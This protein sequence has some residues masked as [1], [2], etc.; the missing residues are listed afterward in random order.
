M[1]Q[2]EI[3]SG[4]QSDWA[5]LKKLGE[6]DAGE[7][8]LVRSQSQT[9]G[10]DPAQGSIAILK[11]PRKSP[12]SSDV[13]RQ[14]AQ[15]ETEGRILKAIHA[16]PDANG[17]QP[18]A[19]LE[20]GE[21][22]AASGSPANETATSTEAHP[23]AKTYC[24]PALLDTAPLS[25][26]ASDRYFI[27]IEKAPGFDLA[28]LARVAM[29]GRVAAAGTTLTPEE[30]LYLHTISQSRKVP[31][32]VVLGALVGLLDLF[33]KIHSLPI[34]GERDEP[35]AAGVIWNDVKPEHL[36]WDPTRVEGDLPAL[37]VIDWG[38]GR[39]LGSDGA[40]VDRRSSRL[41]D[42][43]Q[44]V[45]EMGRFLTLT[46]PDLKA[47]LGWPEQVT[48]ETASPAGFQVLKKKL[49]QALAECR[50]GLKAARKHEAAFFKLDPQTGDPFSLL[51]EV[52]RQ[53]VAYGA[54]PDYAAALLFSQSYAAVFVQEDR[55]DTLRA[56]A[57]WAALLPQAQPESWATIARIAGLAAA[58][59]GER[60][61]RFLDAVQ[62]VVVQDWEAVLWH[63]VEAI[64]DQPEPDWW[65]DLSAVVRRQSLQRLQGQAG[66]PA[67]AGGASSLLTP[68]APA[69]DVVPLVSVKRIL[70]ALQA[71]IRQIEDRAAAGKAPLPGANGHPAP[72]AEHLRALVRRLREEI[73]PNWLRVDP[74]PPFSNLLYTDIDALLEELAGEMPDLGDA[75]LQALQRPRQAAGAVLD[76]W[77]RQEFVRAG[78]LL[79]AVLLVDPDRRRVLRADR[80]ILNTP[81]WLK[82]VQLGPRRSENLRDFATR[83]EFEGRELR[84][85]VGPAD[86][87]DRILEACK[88]LRRSAWPADLLAADPDLIREMPWLNVFERGDGG[89][90]AESREQR[91]EN[92]QRVD[93][94]IRNRSISNWSIGDS[95]VSSQ[96]LIP[97]PESPISD[98]QSPIT[99]PQSLFTGS[100]GP[101]ADMELSAA[102]DA[103]LPEAR[104]SSARVYSGRLLQPDGQYLPAA[105][106][107][108][109]VDK[110]D[111]ALPLFHEEAQI[112]NL[113]NGV[114][115]VTPMLECGFIH[116]EKDQ[117]L[118]DETAA[119]SPTGE[120]LR[121]GADSPAAFQAEL[122]ARVQAGWVPY[123]AIEPQ[124]KK[125]CLL[126]FCDA[127]YTRGRFL[128][129]PE[130]VRMSI[131]ICDLLQIAHDRSIVYRDHKILHYYW[132]REQN[133]VWM[134][135]WNVARYHPEG[136][137][138]VEK[139]MDLVQFGARAL[140]HILTGRT[141]P[142]A[143]PMGPTRPEEIENAASTYE[144]QWTYD[145]QR[146]TEELKGIL[147]TVLLGGYTRPDLLAVDLKQA[148]FHLS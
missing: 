25:A 95:D 38:N 51:T 40:T 74:A 143:L 83:V 108:M 35:G 2:P 102:L 50:K 85:Q 104:G 115:G 69:A 119:T 14:A 16:S 121:I 107:L 122:A 124:A 142:G 73:I 39:M 111:Y 29:M 93:P 92:G 62:S 19:E 8:Y 70:L 34:S 94:V 71:V 45:E 49:R 110:T 64:Y 145:D 133:S 132:I 1:L 99:N 78:Q 125:D 101:N 6:G 10:Q 59:E 112:L 81:G 47:R 21:A 23:Q 141:A 48:F 53:I 68:A 144:V 140:H 77:K 131:Q 72:D 27:V 118:P 13:L 7:V 36:F 52:H 17:S 97:D 120:L 88:Q 127:G 135:D 12:F 80:A 9:P 54:M 44:L 18:D 11:R 105:V 96:S 137:T 103:W 60:R 109:R 5:L 138:E 128:P 130:L 67:P 61:R 87:L 79:R 90:R 116:F 42:Y 106:K 33:E 30:N 123:I 3:C 15:I 139:Q 89:R 57:E 37:T 136:L 28:F 4:Q 41:D 129:L 22:S 98:R 114:P 117:K 32:R 113:L 46:A 75:T 56:V 63:L 100:L 58:A 82:K 31:E 20:P 134:I 91:V 146:L 65:Y 43:R 55:L 24:V 66:A 126:G 148:Y 147:Q 26:R 84:N 76:A 86:W